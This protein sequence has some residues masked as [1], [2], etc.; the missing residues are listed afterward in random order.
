MKNAE[1]TKKRREEEEKQKTNTP[2]RLKPNIGIKTRNQTEAEIIFRE[3]VWI[4]GSRQ[5]PVDQKPWTAFERRIQ[6]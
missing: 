4:S 5:D 3:A 2:K 6:R 1:E